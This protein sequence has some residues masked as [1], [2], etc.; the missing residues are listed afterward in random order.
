MREPLGRLHAPVVQR[1]GRQLLLRP[2]DEEVRV[3]VHPRMVRRHM[4]GN[5]VE[6]QPQAARAQAFPQPGKGLV[7]AK[8]GVDVIVA[9]RKARPGDVGVAEVRQH[10]VILRHPLGMGHRHL[11]C[12]LAGLPDAQEPDQIEAIGCEPIELSIA[13]VVQRRRAA[14]R[15]RQFGQADAGV[16]LEERGIASRRHQSSCGQASDRGLPQRSSKPARRRQHPR[17]Y[18]MCSLRCPVGV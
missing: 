1:F 12:R 17:V 8:V 18:L 9:N 5:E 7:S 15:G 4:V 6:D 14:E 10:P 11:A 13:H 2:G 16:D 3:L